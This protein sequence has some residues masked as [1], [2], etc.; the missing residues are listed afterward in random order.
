M[1]KSVSRKPAAKPAKTGAGWIACV[2][3]MV[4]AIGVAMPAAL[5]ILAL[6]LIPSA[7][8]FIT[9]RIPGR[10]LFRTVLPLNLAGVLI[11]VVA[12]W[13][14]RGGLID[15]IRILETPLAW[16]V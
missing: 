16:L 14:D 7:T 12:L 5:L 10:P 4:A 11:Y 15:A 3:M 2:I 13:H 6:G 8:A 9:D 1:A